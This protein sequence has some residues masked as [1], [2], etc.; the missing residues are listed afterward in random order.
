MKT[1]MKIAALFLLTGIMILMYVIPAFATEI[2]PRLTN[3]STA[4][5]TFGV[6]N[7][8]AEVV[9][10]YFGRA[11]N[12]LRAEVTVKV[13]KK[14]LLLFWK[15]VT[16]WSGS[17]TDVNGVIAGTFPADGDG[18]YR[19][20]ITLTVYGKNGVNDVIEDVIETTAG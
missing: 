15:D 5:M 9:V 18:K 14:F 20:T 7:N 19:A 17:S 8:T 16:E 3:I 10:D 13:E 11:D 6:Y 4:A 1:K 12:F 2:N